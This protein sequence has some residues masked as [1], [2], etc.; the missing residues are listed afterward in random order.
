MPDCLQVPILFKIQ[1]LTDLGTFL[2][3]AADD[4]A[5]LTCA[6]APDEAHDEKHYVGAAEND[7][8]KKLEQAPPAESVC[9]AYDAASSRIVSRAPCKTSNQSQ[10]AKRE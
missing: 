6:A 8:Q 2:A 1:T 5:M 10:C 4:N 7:R 3:R 9:I